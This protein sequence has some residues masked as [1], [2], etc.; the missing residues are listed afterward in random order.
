MFSDDGNRF[1]DA[2]LDSALDDTFA[3][4]PYEAFATGVRIDDER[5]EV[6]IAL[7]HDDEDSAE[8][9]AE[10]LEIVID[11]A[12]S[13]AYESAWSDLVSLD[14]TEV[15]GSVLLATLDFDDPHLATLWSQ[16]VSTRDTL[17]YAD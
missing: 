9:N 15:D 16:V 13:V 5:A 11:R 12:E 14:S 1:D 10:N 6:L 4:E 3:L 2:Y 7:L 17:L 8:R